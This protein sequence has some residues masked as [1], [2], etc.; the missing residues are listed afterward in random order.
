MGQPRRHWRWG[1]PG[2]ALTVSGVINNPFRPMFT[3]LR[4]SRP[5]ASPSTPG[6]NDEI[7]SY[8]PG[9][10][11]CLFGD[12]SV[13]FLKATTNVVVLRSLVT[14]NAGEVISSDQY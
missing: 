5:P 9:G 4:R 11:N 10:A 1:E 7:F 2:N 6:A 12:G 13:K 14:I 8:H 3:E